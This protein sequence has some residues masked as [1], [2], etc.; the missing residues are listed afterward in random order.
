MDTFWTKFADFCNRRG[1]FGVAA[2]WKGCHVRAGKSRLW[3]DNYSLEWTKVL[4]SIESGKRSGLSGE[5]T[6]K[7]A[8]IYTTAQVKEARLRM[9][10]R[11]ESRENNVDFEDQDLAFDKDLEN[12]G[13]VVR[14]LKRLVRKCVLRCWLSEEWWKKRDPVN[15]ARLLK[16]FGGLNFYDPDHEVVYMV[17]TG[18][19]D[20]ERRWR[21]A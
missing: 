21:L 4:G 20:W 19:L 11:E 16:K 13:I 7:H 8:L 17:H 1:V 6:E 12:V 3:H 5:S 15:K 18:N 10:A 2:R 9:S 14:E